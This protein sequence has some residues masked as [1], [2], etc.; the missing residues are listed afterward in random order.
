MKKIN[1]NLIG[2]ILLIP[3]FLISCYDFSDNDS[4]ATVNEDNHS[5]RIKK[6]N[7]AFLRLTDGFW[8][9]WKMNIDGTNQLQLTHSPVDKVHMAWGPDNNELLYHTNRGDTYIIKLESG[10]EKRILNEYK[11]IDAA[12]SPDGQTLAY[13]LS[14]EDLS[15]GKTSL[16]TSD[17]KGKNRNQVAGDDKSDALAPM[18][19]KS[20][21]ELVFRQCFM[22]NNMQVYHD[23]WV[24]DKMGNNRQPILGESEMLKFDQAVSNHGMLAYSSARSGFFEIWIIPVAGGQPGQ[25]TEFNEYAGNPSWSGDGKSIA[26][27][28]DA[29]NSQQLYRID[30]DGKKL[31][32]LTHSNNPSRKPVWSHAVNVPN[33]VNSGTFP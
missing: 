23:F 17:L 6:E 29:G 20:G 7:I 9:L 31:Q 32:Q 19:S 12:W 5:E 26:F 11:I 15:S 25:I 1:F 30:V 13:G 16:W 18:W 24:S 33:E 14:P 8:Q 28:S 21:D 2:S 3:I 4:I 10:E 27:D 22:A